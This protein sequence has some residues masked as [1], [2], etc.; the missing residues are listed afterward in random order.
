MKKFLTRTLT[1]LI[2]VAIVITSILAGKI[3]AFLL[4]GFFIGAILFETKKL[5]KFKN[6]FSLV[7]YMLLAIL[8]YF[9]SVFGSQQ[10][11]PTQWGALMLVFLFSTFIVVSTN[12][13]KLSGFIAH[14]GLFFYVTIPFI[15]YL[16]I[17][18]FSEIIYK[19]HYIIPIVIISMIWINDTASYILGML[20][21]KQKAFP[22]ISPGKTWGGYIYGFIASILSIVIFW[23]IIKEVPLLHLILFSIISFIFGSVGDLIESSLKRKAE[24]KDLSKI[25]PGHGGVFD[26]FDSFIFALPFITLLILTLY[27]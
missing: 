10:F 25:L 24:L 5:F 3:Y 4:F 17:F 21:G 15:F 18:D 6:N 8:F 14:T 13:L 20:F 1:A 22:K 23:A 16:R 2:F 26:R 7:L 27:F 19:N 9:L 12:N 11:T